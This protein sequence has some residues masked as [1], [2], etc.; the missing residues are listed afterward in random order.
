MVY[1]GRLGERACAVKLPLVGG[2]WTRW[3]Y[4][5]AVALARV[6]HPGLATVLEVGECD[7]VPFIATDLVEG[8]TLDARL[9]RGPLPV[10][11]VVALGIELAAA[12]EAVHAVGLVHRDVKPRNV[13]LGRDGHSRLI[14][15]GF[16]VPFEAA[17]RMTEWAGTRGYSAPEQMLFGGRVDGRSDLFAL[18][19]VLRECLLGRG[20]RFVAE[21]DLTGLEAVAPRLVPV[22]D[23]LVAADP[24]QRYPD[25]PAVLRDLESVA[26]GGTARGPRG[27]VPELRAPS[28]VG[29]ADAL[30]R[31]NRSWLSAGVLGGRVALLK[32]SRGMGKTSLLQ[33]SAVAAKASGSACVLEVAC[34]ENEA[35]LTTLRRIFEA[36]ISSWQGEDARTAEDVVAAALDER[37][38]AF[39]HLIG[40]R[41]A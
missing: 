23:G 24:F 25:A 2:A 33:A 21:A 36:F 13:V 34:L 9:R 35:P 28:L 5:E 40:F 4:R 26:Q 16:A 27:Y 37:L 14:D 10:E 22:L 19:R 15:F 38:S 8:E 32:G 12:L 17:S 7:G 6:R 29:R 11:Q 30:G 39:A 1:R 31:L 3:V 18:G 20:P 41:G